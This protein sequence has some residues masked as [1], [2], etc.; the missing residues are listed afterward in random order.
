MKTI[1]TQLIKQIDGRMEQE[2]RRHNPPQITPFITHSHLQSFP[3]GKT[4]ILKI[5]LSVFS[6][7]SNPGKDNTA[8]LTLEGR[9]FQT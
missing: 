6:K 1:V 9:S 8:D 3:V 4:S 7:K 2:S 5:E